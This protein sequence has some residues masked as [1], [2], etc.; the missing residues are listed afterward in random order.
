MKDNNKKEPKDDIEK[1]QPDAGYDIK[2]NPEYLDV[3]N[4]YLRLAA[5]FENARK[6][7]DRDRD[8]L[9]KYGESA[10]IKEVLV[11]IDELQQACSMAREHKDSEQIARGFEMTCKN[12]EAILKKRGLEA[13]ESVGKPFDPHFQEIS[14]SRPVE[15]IDAH[16]VL[17]EVQKGYMLADKVLRTAKVIVGVPKETADHRPETGDQKE[18]EGLGEA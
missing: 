17:E 12:F 1:L 13:I 4:K 11:I 8:D 7:W 5:E 6:R 9:L 14:A 2:T 10:L 18:E 15:G 16:M 3:L